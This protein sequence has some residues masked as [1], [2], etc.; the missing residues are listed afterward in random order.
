MDTKDGRL[1]VTLT[2]PE[3]RELLQ[4]LVPLFA[5]ALKQEVVGTVE[6]AVAAE[7]SKLGEERGQE[8][9]DP[10]S[11]LVDVKEVA[12]LLGLSRR[13]VWKMSTCGML[14]PPIKLGRSSR[15]RRRDIESWIDGKA[16]AAEN[17]RQQLAKKW[18]GSR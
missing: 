7:V 6:A 15:W 2:V 8:K 13:T 17:E 18:R 16:Q 14:P 5:D 4:S 1:M 9:P 12:Q 3:L 11:R 10:P